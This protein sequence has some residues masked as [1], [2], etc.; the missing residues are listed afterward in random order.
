MK[1]LNHPTADQL[2]FQWNECRWSKFHHPFVRQYHRRNLDGL[3]LR[4]SATHSAIILDRLQFLAGL[5]EKKVFLK[6]VLIHI[7]TNYSLTSNLGMFEISN[8][9][10]RLSEALAC[11][12]FIKYT[13]PPQHV[14]EAKIFF[15]KSEALSKNFPTF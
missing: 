13:P 11:F 12:F 6:Y 15:K 9:S 7:F 3:G 14:I 5:L 1:V 4:Y 10:G 8:C 2:K